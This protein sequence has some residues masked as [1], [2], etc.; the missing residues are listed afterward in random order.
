MRKQNISLL[1]S[2]VA[3]VIVLLFMIISLSACWLKG[4]TFV[5]L[6]LTLLAVIWYTYFTYQLAVKKEQPVV[7]AGIHYIPEAKDVR[8]GVENPTNRYAGTRV[9]VQTQ[10]YGQN[11]DLGPDY[12]GQTIW[13]L[14]PQFSIEGH[15]PLEKP[16]LQIG[17]NFNTMVNEANDEN[18]NRQLRLS[19]KVEWKDE[20]GNIGKY[21]EHFWYFD[22]RGNGFVYQVGGFRS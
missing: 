4:G 6:S 2:F 5:I 21:P 12:S 14:T 16:L 8:I 18:A 10:V 22:F 9:W 3:T 1:I 7:V 15:F 13:H 20:E 11:T 17:K 19:L